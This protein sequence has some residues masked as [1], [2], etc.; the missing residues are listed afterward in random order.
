MATLVTPSECPKPVPL[1]P[2]EEEKGLC[3]LFDC[4]RDSALGRPKS[5]LDG[6]Q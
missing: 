3:S 6:L 5:G 2:V 1:T 4:C